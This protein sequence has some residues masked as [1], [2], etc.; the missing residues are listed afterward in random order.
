MWHNDRPFIFLN[1]QKS[2]E[3]CR[4]DAAHELGHL[5]MH[6]HGISQ[7][8]E[9]EKEANMFAS[10]FLMPR[11]SIL[12]IAPRLPTLEKL[13]AIKKYWGVSVAALNYRIHAISLTSE[14][15]Y[16]TLCKQIAQAGYRR[17]EPD[18]LPRETSQTLNKIFTVLRSEK[19]TKYTLA[20]ELKVSAQ[21]I[22]ELTYGL[23]DLFIISSEPYSKNN[24]TQPKLRLVK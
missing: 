5:V 12:S 24:G 15:I 8:L 4:F 6:R 7:G 23:M 11:S 10:A 17:N 20:K 18:G 13:I 2:A 21:E 22:D 1:N 3:H 14:W 16:R 9:I 19:V